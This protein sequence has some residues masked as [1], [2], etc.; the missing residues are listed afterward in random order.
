MAELAM[1]IIVAE[2]RMPSLCSS[3]CITWVKEEK[4]S[5]LGCKLTG[6]KDQTGNVV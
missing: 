4:K 5:V 2:V 3:A 1:K 6:L